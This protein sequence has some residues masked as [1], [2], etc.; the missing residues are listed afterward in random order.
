[1]TPSRLGLLQKIGFEFDLGQR[2]LSEADTRWQMRLNELKAY[3]EKW[4]TF[5]VKQSHNLTLYN[6]CQHQKAKL[7]RKE[8]KKER[9][10]ALRSLGFLY[11]S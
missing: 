4:G 1:M 2:L 6:W 8:L 10:D 7:R 9:E 5:H 11:S 3:E